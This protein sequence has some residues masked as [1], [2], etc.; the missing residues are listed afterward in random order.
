MKNQSTKNPENQDQRSSLNIRWLLGVLPFM[1]V[2]VLT[3]SFVLLGGGTR[4]ELNPN[5]HRSPSHIKE[6]DT[7]SAFNADVPQAEVEEL[8][9]SKLEA[10]KKEEEEEL[11]KQ[12]RYK[13][14]NEAI[15]S[16]S[17]YDN[18]YSQIMNEEN[19]PSEEVRA[20]RA[21]LYDDYDEYGENQ[22]YGYEEDSPVYIARSYQAGDKQSSYDEKQDSLIA[23]LLS[24]QQ[25]IDDSNK[26]PAREAKSIVSIPHQEA[27]LVSTLS[28]STANLDSTQSEA[29]LQDNR[30]YG[31]EEDN[32]S[33]LVSNGSTK[34]AIAAVV[35][36]NQEIMSGNTVKLRLQTD[37]GVN[38]VLIPAGSFIH[39][40]ASFSGE[41]VRI[42]IEAI[43][44][45]GNLFEVELTAYDID[46][47]AGIKA[48]SILVS[49]LKKEFK[50][51]QEES[52]DSAEN[53]VELGDSLGGQIGSSALKS[54]K[55]LFGGKKLK[56]Q[57]ITL[58]SGYQVLLL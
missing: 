29:Q 52:L 40:T 38:G 53:E 10:Y 23:L 26:A 28:P 22:G 30:F 50:E 11:A 1:M 42:T 8:P 13:K 2:L 35:H 41:R 58:K 9:E 21:E 24:K 25:E 14:E 18:L 54:T 39:G 33:S 15:Q 20:G 55:K 43:Q 27:E 4:I 31:L 12:E 5:N 34:N 7:L 17:E 56:A 37:I 3:S 19:E 6:L 57:K 49:E 44:Y 47:I 51:A 36:G 46:G 45:Q 32:P 48:P 16:L